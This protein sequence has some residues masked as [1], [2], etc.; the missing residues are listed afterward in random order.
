[1]STNAGSSIVSSKAARVL[2]ASQH[3]FKPLEFFLVPEELNPFDDRVQ[4]FGVS[5]RGSDG[6]SKSI[7]VRG[8][9]QSALEQGRLDGVTELV[10]ATSGNTGFALALMARQP[11]YCI[12]N[13][14]LVV[15]PD[16]PAPKRTM[17]LLAGARIIYPESGL[18]A[19]ETA[20]RLGNRWAE[21][22][23]EWKPVEGRLNLDQYANPANLSL[24]EGW[25]GPQILE[26]LGS[27]D[28]FAAALGTGGTV[29]GLRNY[30][31][32]RM[33]VTM[34]GVACAPGNEIPGARDVK[35]LAEVSLPWR[36]SIDTLEEVGQK[37]A[38]AMACWL[39]QITGQ[40][41][42][43]SGGMALVGL[44][45]A[46]ERSHGNRARGDEKIKAVFFIPDGPERYADRFEA[47]LPSQ[48]F[49][50]APD[51]PLQWDSILGQWNL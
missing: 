9:L 45:K 30:F 48:F 14:T 40:P 50:G 8:M 25:T 16:I 4:I 2:D 38:Y 15:A 24:H 46:I 51:L 32:A 42:G 5:A 21:R 18:T 22:S 10:E 11:P 29:I 13:V 1:M 28:I 43:P 19:I 37:Q 3:A 23:G 26:K 20:R 33:R 35:R 44:L 31:G 7:T 12:D 6:G 17:L 27:F 39:T 34:V 47:N 41:V 36:S 49:N